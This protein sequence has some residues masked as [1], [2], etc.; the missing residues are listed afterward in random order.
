METVVTGARYLSLWR[1][2]LI[3]FAHFQPNSLRVV[4]ILSYHLHVGLPSGVL[5]PGISSQITTVRCRLTVRVK[6]RVWGR[7]KRTVTCGAFPAE[8]QA[9]HAPRFLSR[10]P[11]PVWPVPPVELGDASHC[12][13][14]VSREVSLTVDSIILNHLY[15]RFCVDMVKNCC[16]SSYK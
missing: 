15:L 10:H 4:L 1:T 12:S 5:T 13:R 16:W 3:E 2:G 11:A 9:K 6:C 7:L 14:A 8:R